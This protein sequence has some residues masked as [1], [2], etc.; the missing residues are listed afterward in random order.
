MKTL[1][2]EIRELDRAAQIR[3]YFSVRY[4]KPPREY[5]NGFRFDVGLADKSGEMDLTYW[6]GRD[7]EAVQATY[8]SFSGDDVIYVFGTVGEYREKKTIDVNEGRGEIRQANTEEYTLDDFLVT[9]NQSIEEMWRKIVEIKESI[10][11]PHLKSLLD[12]FFG[13]STFVEGFKK[14]PAAISIHHACIGGL[15]EHTWEV[16]RY[17]E[18]VADV[19]SSLDKALLFTA[20]IL[21]DVGKI[22]E[23][24]VSTIIKQSKKGMLV[25]HSYIGNEL[26]LEKISGLP[27]FPPLLKDKLIHMIL[28]HMGTK[29]YGAGQ[30]PKLPE[31][32]AL[33]YADEMGAKITQYIRA[34]KDTVTDDFRTPRFRRIGSIFLE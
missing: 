25:G 28:S 21:H 4:K 31:A 17:C 8:D 2:S 34:K 7:A 23:Y 13:D 22:E 5:V 12:A 10:D 14:A 24:D 3:S 9:T 18:A 11:N 20:A 29:E 30:E 1:I 27:N 19:H 33:H 32:A 6:G 26:V 15:L 16:L